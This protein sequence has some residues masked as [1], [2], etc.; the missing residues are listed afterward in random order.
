MPGRVVEVHVQAGQPVARGQLLVILEAMKMEQTLQAPHDGRVEAVHCAAG[1]LVD[2]GAVL[3]TLVPLDA[4]P[5]G[6]D[7]S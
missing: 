4:E 3:I 1:D 6:D 7:P 2:A 5:T